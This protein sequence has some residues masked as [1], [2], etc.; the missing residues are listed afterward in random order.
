VGA[1]LV[2]W[3]AKVAVTLT[4]LAY[5]AVGYFVLN[6]WDFPDRF[7]VPLTPLDDAP[8]IPWTIVV[9]HSV[10]VLSALGIWLH[11]NQTA[12]RVY[13]GA[14]LVGYTISYIIFAFYPTYIERPQLP[15]SGSMWLWAVDLTWSVDQPH[16]CF[17]SLHMVNCFVPVSAFFK[18]RLGVPLLLWSIVIAASAITVRQH[19]FWDLP[20]GSA[21][22]VIGYWIAATANRRFSSA[23]Q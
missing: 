22:G 14:V 23:P 21:I 5:W 15:E 7:D 2:E 9:Y 12:L 19:F 11:Q 20:T 13:L 16:T 18:T 8:L 1:L 10:Y 6:H 4:I 3:R 17:P